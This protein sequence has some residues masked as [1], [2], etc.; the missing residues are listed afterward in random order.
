M[1]QRIE[2]KGSW[3]EN[4]LCLREGWVKRRLELGGKEALSRGSPSGNESCA[5]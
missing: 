1:G 4:E 2:D 3:K 5:L